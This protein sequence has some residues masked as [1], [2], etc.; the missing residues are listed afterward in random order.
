MGE[1][2]MSRDVDHRKEKGDP[3]VTQLEG[4]DESSPINRHVRGVCVGVALVSNASSCA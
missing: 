4:E 1:R 3:P 2:R